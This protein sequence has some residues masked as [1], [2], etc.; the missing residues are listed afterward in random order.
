[1]VTHNCFAFVIPL[2]A[3]FIIVTN[4]CFAMGF[5]ILAIYF[6]LKNS[7][8]VTIFDV[9]TYKINGTLKKQYSKVLFSFHYW[10]C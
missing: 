7:F 10:I 4:C 3:S 9:K 8:F 6:Q 2:Y 1:M 5:I